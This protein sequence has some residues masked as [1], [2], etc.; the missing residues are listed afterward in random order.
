MEHNKKRKSKIRV[1]KLLCCL[2]ML[3]AVLGFV[4]W[5]IGKGITYLSTRPSTEN[6]RP[7]Y[8]LF[9]GAD[10][11]AGNQADAV[12]LL[13]RNDKKQEATFISIPSNTRIAGRQEGKSMLL[14]ETFAEGGSEETKS[15]IENLLHIRIDA[16]AVVN[17]ADFENYMSHWGPV[18]M[19]VEQYMEHTDATGQ[20]DIGL[21]QGYQSLGQQDALGYVRF[22]E[23]DNGEVG[24][25]QRQERFM[26]T[27]LGKMQS[28]NALY[29][30][31]MVHHYWNAVE[32]DLT[33]EEAGKL[34][35]HLTNYPAAGCKFIIFPGELQKTGKEQAWVVNP[36]EVQKAIAMTME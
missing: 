5:G 14:R 23:K 2:V 30:W 10:E 20:N 24:R 6:G 22:I 15:A 34:A 36:V 31:A 7:M 28:H 33:A 18:D 12:I 32:T 35:Y 9:I 26:K 29:N 25:L 4:I 8:Y 17:Y 21:F 1:K 11:K 19:Y 16:Y 13:A 3:I 27:L